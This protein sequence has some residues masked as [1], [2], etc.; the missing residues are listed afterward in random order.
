MT[1]LIAIEMLFS[2]ITASFNDST[3]TTIKSLEYSYERLPTTYYFRGN[4]GNKVV[5]VTKGYEKKEFEQ[6]NNSI[7]ILEEN[8]R[9]YGD[10]KYDEVKGK[11]FDALYVILDADYVDENKRISSS[12]VDRITTSVNTVIYL[13][14]KSSSV[15]AF[16]K[17]I[18]NTN[19][20][21]I[22]DSKYDYKYFADGTRK[23]TKRGFWKE[24]CEGP[25]PDVRIG[26]CCGHI[27][28]ASGTSVNVF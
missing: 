1:L 19:L 16:D 17:A 15:K 4:S 8:L 18:S 23:S 11:A 22:K 20:Q 24:W 10:D 7:N 21:K 25:Y 28:V 6:L 14:K 12:M 9:K 3:T 13:L 5:T 27:Y 2:L 26:T